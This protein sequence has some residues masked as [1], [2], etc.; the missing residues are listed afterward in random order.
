MF[1]DDSVVSATAGLGSDV[2]CCVGAVASPV[3][4]LAAVAGPD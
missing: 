3:A 1:V 2:G 4:V